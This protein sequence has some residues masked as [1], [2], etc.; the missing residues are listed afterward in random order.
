MDKPTVLIGRNLP[1]S[2]Y[3]PLTGRCNIIV[4]AEDRPFSREE[5]LAHVKGC[6]AALVVLNRVDEEVCAAAAPTCKVFANFG[7]GYDNISVPAATA[8]GIWVSNTPDVVTDVTADMAWALLLAA[9]RRLAESDRLIRAGGWKNWGPLFMLG[10]DVSGR[11]LGIVGA[12]RIGQAMA[13]RAL[14]FNMDIL[15]TANSPKPDFE[16]ATGARFADLPTLLREADYISLHVPLSKATRHLIG[17]SEL[18]LMKKTAILVNTARGPVVDEK[19]LVAALEKGVIAGAGL[20]VF[21]NEP[22]VEPGLMKLDNVVLAPHI[23]GATLQTRVNMGRMACRNIL[24]ALRGEQPPNCVNP[25]A[26]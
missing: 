11:T 20:D 26:R 7:V 22:Q 6:D 23:G 14:G 21:E 4:P 19:A 13:K 10:S 2:F 16:A 5:F 8:Q 3:E 25:G 17:A 1:E 18:A 24:A 12:G 15:Y 9:A